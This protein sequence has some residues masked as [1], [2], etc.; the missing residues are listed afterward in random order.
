M[1]T[2]PQCGKELPAFTVGDPTGL[3]P[4]CLQRQQM[5]TATQQQAQ[6]FSNKPTLADDAR[7][8]PITSAIV[9][10]NVVVYV[11]CVAFSYATGQ[12]S[13]V[14]FSPQLLAQLGANFGPYT[15][16]G[17]WWRL[18][19]CMWMHGGL[20]HIGANMYCFWSF[21]RIAERIFGPKR[22]TA[23]YLITGISSSVASVAWHPF[24]V[25]IGASGAIFGVAGALFVP[26]YRKRLKLPPPVMSSML[27]S[28]GM[29]IV[30]NLIIG[31]SLPFIDMSAHLGGLVAGFILGNV[32]VQM[33][34]AGEQAVGKVA[35]VA[36]VLLAGAFFAIRHERWPQIEK[37]LQQLQQNNG[38]PAPQ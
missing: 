19:T 6:P 30:I 9:A 34:A 17:Q 26:F 29:F 11:L 13:V 22:Y 1:S 36:L 35:I 28:I 3:C 8:F 31:A 18:F 24:I 37:R 21:G 2:C 33:A 15:L 25:S 20:I 32:F 23:I 4:E 38:A 14:D 27:R 12:L 10:I 7:T 5:A 16:D